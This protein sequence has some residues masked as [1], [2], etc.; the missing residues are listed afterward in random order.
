MLTELTCVMPLSCMLSWL[1]AAWMDPIQSPSMTIAGTLSCERLL[2]CRGNGNEQAHTAVV[3]QA[4]A[5][6]C[7]LATKMKSTAGESGHQHSRPHQ[8]KILGDTSCA[9]FREKTER[10]PQQQQHRG[11]SLRVQ[12][13]YNYRINSS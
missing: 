3:R 7:A 12:K 13:A 6:G 2:M 9:C 11:E 4:E 8:Q 10:R 1:N 5:G